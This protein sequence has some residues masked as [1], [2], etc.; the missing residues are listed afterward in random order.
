MLPRGISTSTVGHRF[1]WECG[2]MTAGPFSEGPLH[3]SWQAYNEAV[4]AA[5]RS[6]AVRV[7]ELQAEN[8]A[9]KTA[10]RNFKNRAVAMR[11]TQSRPEYSGLLKIHQS[12]RKIAAV[13]YCSPEYLVMWLK[14]YACFDW[15]LYN[16]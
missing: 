4:E 5:V 14:H 8:E 13:D 11:A 3:K 1:D 2:Y 7:I 12:G 10:M 16:T 9:L 6:D 15:I